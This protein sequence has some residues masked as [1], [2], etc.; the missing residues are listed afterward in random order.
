MF[1]RT[2]RLL[3]RPSWEDDAP[4]LHEAIAHEAVAMKLARLPWPYSEADARDFLAAQAEAHAPHM[5]IFARTA[6]KPR[7]VGGIGLD[8]NGCAAELGY[9]ISPRYWGLGFATEAARAVI[10]MART[11]LPCRK[12]TAHHYVDNPASGNVLRK[13]GFRRTNRVI[14]RPCLARGHDVAAF[15]Y[16]LDFAEKGDCPDDNLAGRTLLAA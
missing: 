10:D 4:A 12:L 6:G 11:A 1:A 5:L 14:A 13:L 2:E 16:V 3:L 15:D 7:L 9:W 8:V